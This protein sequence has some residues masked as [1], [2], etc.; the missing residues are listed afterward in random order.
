MI[1]SPI[2]PSSG[3]GATTWKKLNMQAVTETRA[4]TPGRP[5]AFSIQTDKRPQFI[6]LTNSS[7]VED[8]QY[9]SG[10]VWDNGS[11]TYRAMK[12]SVIDLAA[13]DAEYSNG[14]ITGTI[15]LNVESVGE[16]VYYALI[17]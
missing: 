17:F 15:S 11:S 8:M 1:T 6:L 12:T 2:F 3:G 7:V 14:E 10:F 16:N 5:Y 9:G 13:Y 4:G